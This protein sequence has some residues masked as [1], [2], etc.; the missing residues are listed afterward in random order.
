MCNMIGQFRELHGLL[1]SKVCLIWFLP[2]F[3]NPERETKYCTD[4]LFLVTAVSYRTLFF[5]PQI[6]GLHVL[7]L[8]YKCQLKK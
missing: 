1:K 3:L 4:L 6:Y 5:T 7:P 2:L 8:G